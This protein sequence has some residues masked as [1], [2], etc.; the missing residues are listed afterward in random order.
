MN[1]A[2]TQG[3]SSLFGHFPLSVWRDASQTPSSEAWHDFP[4]DSV[5][6][7]STHVQS[8]QA[9][10]SMPYGVSHVIG[11]FCRAH[12]VGLAPQGMALGPPNRD[13]LGREDAKRLLGVWSNTLGD[14]TAPS[15]QFLD[16]QPDYHLPL[17][18]SVSTAASSR[19]STSSP[20]K[21]PSP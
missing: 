11:E 17:S 13:K 4:R 9:L 15:I 14:E 16:G 6:T 7:V 21:Y 19:A 8:T 12:I 10:H 20:P 1:L 18:F 3:L 2:Q 5:A